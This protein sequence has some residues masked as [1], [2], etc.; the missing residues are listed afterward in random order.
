MAPSFLS[1][2]SIFTL[3]FS[4]FLYYHKQTIQTKKFMLLYQPII[5]TASGNVAYFEALIRIEDLPISPSDFIPV[6]EESNLILPMG[7]WVIEEAINQLLE[8]EQM[9]L[10]VKP[11][12]INFSPKQ[13][14]DQ[15]LE[16]FLVDQL[17]KNNIEP[18]LI[19]IEITENV[20]IDNVEEVIKIINSFKALGIKISLD[21]FGTGYSS[22]NYITRIPVD[23]IKLDRSLT[24]KLAENL[25]V[26]ESL[27]AIAHGMDMEV[28]GEGVEKINESYLLSK[29]GCDYLQGYLFS[30]PVKAEI[31]YKLLEKNFGKLI[32][33][34]KDRL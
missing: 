6:A 22:I 5:D 15:G 17:A 34:K 7:R 10:S 9:G 24:G 3:P 21:D 31:A 4:R 27:V 12:A 29:S 26:L 20:L 25:P 30:M 33:E 11:I 16:A 13:F 23:R 19:E 18:S 2:P 28:V 8:W 14:F 32:F 1:E